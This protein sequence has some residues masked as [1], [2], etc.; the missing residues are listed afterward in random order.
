MSSSVNEN[1]A[2]MINLSSTGD[3]R[4][5]IKLKLSIQSTFSRR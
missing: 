4:T 5:I 1:E 3:E 2:E